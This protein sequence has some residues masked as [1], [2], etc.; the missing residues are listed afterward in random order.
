VSVQGLAILLVCR[1]SVC[2]CKAWPYCCFAGYLCVCARPGQSVVLQAISVSVQGL[3]IA[4]A[5]SANIV[6]AARGFFISII[7]LESIAAISVIC[8]KVFI[9][10]GGSFYQVMFIFLLYLFLYYMQIT[11]AKPSEIDIEKKVEDVNKE[12]EKNQ[13]SGNVLDKVTFVKEK[14][15]RN[16]N[17]NEKS[18]DCIDQNTNDL[19]FELKVVYGEAEK[20]DEKPEIANKDD[21]SGQN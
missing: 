17:N 1:L 8:S 21:V 7:V 12:S 13:T 6:E 4:E 16:E 20:I 9:R 10:G 2:L 3:A 19:D 18:E 14:L 15:K 11:H 5:V